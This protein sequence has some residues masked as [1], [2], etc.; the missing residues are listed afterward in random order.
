MTVGALR[1][2]LDLQSPSGTSG[3]GYTTE[4]STRGEIRG[5][6]GSELLR[7]GGTSSQGQFVITVRYRDDVKA[8]WRIREQDSGRTFQITSYSDPDGRRQWTQFF[9]TE[10]Q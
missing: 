8:D 6:G 5:A 7:Y 3:Q 4:A 9:C 1:Y 10:I 2:V